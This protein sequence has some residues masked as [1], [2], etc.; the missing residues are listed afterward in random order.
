MK[1]CCFNR[2]KTRHPTAIRHVRPLAGQYPFRRDVTDGILPA[3]WFF[4]FR[5]AGPSDDFQKKAF[6]GLAPNA[7]GT[8]H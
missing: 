1:R 2:A 4:K 6:G 5:R 7:E 3:S 8:G